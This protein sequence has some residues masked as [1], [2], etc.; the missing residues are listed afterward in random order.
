VGGGQWTL[1]RE[2]VE[3]VSGGS[4][5]RPQ[6][7]HYALPSA[8]TQGCLAN[9]RY[10]WSVAPAT[11]H[12]H[13]VSQ[14]AQLKIANKQSIILQHCLFAAYAPRPT[15]PLF[16]STSRGT[17]Q[18]KRSD[19]SKIMPETLRCRR[20]SPP[21]L[22]TAIVHAFCTSSLRQDKARQAWRRASLRAV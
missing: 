4:T 11:F 20:L 21:S 8:W 2:G 22:S 7:G 16:C 9:K 15:K 5:P 18:Q 1:L 3:W 10:V 6:G 17:M 12:N 14:C 13:K 19:G